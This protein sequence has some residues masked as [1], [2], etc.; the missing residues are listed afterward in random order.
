MKKII[1]I[2]VVAMLGITTSNSQEIALG[3]FEVYIDYLKG[4]YKKTT[5]PELILGTPYLDNN[6]QLGS[7]SFKGEKPRTFPMRYNIVNEEFEVQIDNKIYYVQDGVEVKLIDGFFKKFDYRDSKN[8]IFGGYFLTPENEDEDN[9]LIFLE[10]LIKKRIEAKE[11]APMKTRTPAQY[12]DKSEF[13]LKFPDSQFAI[14]A[15]STSKNFIETFP[16]EYR[17]KIRNF[18]KSNKLKTDRRQDLQVIVD[19]YNNVN[20]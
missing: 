2:I 5:V 13:Y 4:E 15:E 8:N 3:N 11:A 17:E 6:F 7:I 19:Y 9:K 12:V 14:L 20:I 18:I 10:K 16:E 1:L